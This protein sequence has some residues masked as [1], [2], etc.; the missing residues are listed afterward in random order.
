MRSSGTRSPM[1]DGFTSRSSSAC[2]SRCR[3]RC[4]K[5]A[6]ITDMPGAPL[7]ETAPNDVERQRA[8][9]GSP[10]GLPRPRGPCPARGRRS[11]SRRS[12]RLCAPSTQSPVLA[13]TVVVPSLHVAQ[14]EALVLRHLP[15]GAF[16]RHFASQAACMAALPSSGQTSG[17]SRSPPQPPQNRTWR[18]FDD[19]EIASPNTLER[20][21]P[22]LA[23]HLVAD[24]H[25]GLEHD[26][27]LAEAR[28]VDAAFGG[29]VLVV[30][31]GEHRVLAA[32]TRRRGRT[33]QTSSE[34]GDLA[35]KELR[36]QLD[37]AIVA[38]PW[39]RCRGRRRPSCR[40]H[41]PRN[42]P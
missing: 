3:R 22:S 2:S 38:A 39:R 24:L 25:D 14:E 16:R 4:P 35:C 33:E 29:L 42:C 26:R 18:P 36:D 21:Y 17:T 7:P 30:V 12:P 23:R 5:R 20:L 27:L 37:Q 31:P 11:S 15:R 10:R 41:P 28:A 9:P 19:T 34:P 13:M 8:V 40:R 6:L 32:G 1:P